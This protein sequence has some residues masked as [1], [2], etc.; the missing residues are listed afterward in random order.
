MRIIFLLSLLVFIFFSCT[1]ADTIPKEIIEKPR[2]QE[3]IWD[4]IRAD[5]FLSDYSGKGDTAFNRVAESISFYQK[6]LTIHNTTKDEF[7][8]SL[9]WYQQHPK[10]MKTILDTLQGRNNKIMQER[11]RP[12]LAPMI[13]T[14]Q[15]DD[16]NKI[17]S[18][19]DSTINPRPNI[20]SLKK[21]RKLGIK[22]VGN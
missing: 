7:K 12:N 3:L 10:V 8:K 15:T 13:D 1:Q 22:P 14:M 17:E 2:M 18:S 6:V 4:M 11:G 16:S 5:V 19:A 9:I 21:R 20:D